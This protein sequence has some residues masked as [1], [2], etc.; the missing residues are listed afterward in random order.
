M[1]S[2]NSPNNGAPSNENVDGSSGIR[3]PAWLLITVTVPQLLLLIFLGRDYE[4]LRTGIEEKFLSYWHVYLGVLALLWVGFSGYCVYCWSGLS[5]GRRISG[6]WLSPVMLLIY[7]VYLYQFLIH[8]PELYSGSVAAWIVSPDSGVIYTMTFLTP[9]LLYAL[10]L[11][12]YELTPKEEAVRRVWWN[13]AGILIV[14]VG[15]YLLFMIL[16]NISFAGDSQLWEFVFPV[17]LISATVAFF[18]LLI[19]GVILLGRGKLGAV[20]NTPTVQIP[21]RLVIGIVFP[22]AGLIFNN[23]GELLGLG[24]MTHVFG[25]FDH[26][27]FYI[28]AVLNG[29]ALALPDRDDIRYRTGLFLARLLL[30]PYSLYFCVIFLPYLPLALIGIII[31]GLG[32]L[33][34]TPLVLT[35]IHIRV[36]LRDYQYLKTA[37]SADLLVPARTIL[38]TGLLAL[39]L[40]PLA[41]TGSYYH[42]RRTLHAALDYVYQPN[43]ASSRAGLDTRALRKVLLEIRRYKSS[44]GTPYLG[45]Y[46]QWLV[47]DNLTVSDAKLDRLQRLFFGEV[48]HP[49]VPDGLWGNQRGGG[50]FGGGGDLRP[51]SANGRL[52][53]VRSRTRYDVQRGLYHSTIDLTLVYPT[54]SGDDAQTEYRT[55]FRLPLGAKISEYYLD[56]AGE[57]QYGMLAEKKSALWIYNQITSFRQDP[58]L[59]YYEDARNLVLRVF[60]IS[61]GRTRTT[62]FEVVHVEP[63]TLNLDGRPIALTAPG[64]RPGLIAFPEGL[65]ISAAAKSKAV[66]GERAPYISFIL[67]C[68]ESDNKKLT[69]FG[70]IKLQNEAYV[71]AMSQ[72]LKND[73]VPGRTREVQV[74]CANYEFASQFVSEPNR[75]ELMRIVEDLREQIPRRGRFAL[76]RIHHALLIQHSRSER[77][78]DR[79]PVMI[80][81]TDINVS[82]AERNLNDLAWIVPETP[83]FYIVKDVSRA[84]QKNSSNESSS[85]PS[86]DSYRFDTQSAAFVGSVN[87]IAFAATV[88]FDS[89]AIAAAAHQ[90]GDLQTGSSSANI[91]L[92]VVVARNREA[93]VVPVIDRILNPGD[94]ALLSD[95]T[96]T[97]DTA[98]QQEQGTAR[99][100]TLATRAMVLAA[101]AIDLNHRLHPAAAADLYLEMVRASFAAHLLLHSTSFLSVETEA[102]KIA[103]KRKQDQILRGHSALDAGEEP[104]RMDEPGFWILAVLS[105]VFLVLWSWR[106]RRLAGIPAPG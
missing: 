51:P 16:A 36:I 87:R 86:I 32:F 24:E 12:V 80:A 79:F 54:G 71:A 46:Y 47:L 20:V 82:R 92:P 105:F 56:I 37:A 66:A 21:L 69:P 60:P 94:S 101:D 104:V 77:A 64:P 39:S 84:T 57:R 11:G 28:L 93:T 67:D 43:Y 106:R 48:E 73:V 8:T 63:F 59:L 52:S 76:N 10:L 4:I 22:L 89:D 50:R 19:R 103:L 83:N 14:P 53:G 30:F 62:G 9:A 26:P 44:A 35:I 25:D 49:P 42:E 96:A 38:I 68:G 34:L 61:R 75:S 17:V 90:A 15:V 88:Q 81:L 97:P 74:T 78:R 3:H 13:F 45:L 1:S 33:M 95:V 55:K 18:F 5:R 99:H 40:W 41:I 23:H 6:A 70:P 102:Q 72:V 29:L 85:T 31:F 91:R 58:G 100:D 2:M 65:Y 7:I 27:A 98:N